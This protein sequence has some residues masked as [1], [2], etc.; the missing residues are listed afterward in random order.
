MYRALFGALYIELSVRAAAI[1]VLMAS[2]VAFAQPCSDPNAEG[3]AF[4]AT[5]YVRPHK[6]DYV[7]EGLV[8]VNDSVRIWRETSDRTC[9]LIETIHRNAHLCWL[10]GEA[11]QVGP[12][13]FAYSDA[14]CKVAIT[15]KGDRLAMQVRDSAEP[16][17]NMCNPADTDLYACGA[18]TAVD[19]GAF[20][21]SR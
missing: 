1:P 20:V 10:R 11:K 5:T 7:G 17:R 14:S 18:N 19:S 3:F 2:A 12:N 13:K 8:S 6:V 16:K 21:R 15:V 4:V 9:F